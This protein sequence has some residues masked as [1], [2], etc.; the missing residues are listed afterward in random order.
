MHQTGDFNTKYSHIE[1]RFK[2]EMFI[3][4]LGVCV[5]NHYE[6]SA[7]EGASNARTFWDIILLVND[8]LS[9]FYK[10]QGRGGYARDRDS[11][12]V[13]NSG[14]GRWVMH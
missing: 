1:S 14:M 11:L 12:F 5:R 13:K 4:T 7:P 8:A 9:V 3:A 2:Q 6:W 10:W